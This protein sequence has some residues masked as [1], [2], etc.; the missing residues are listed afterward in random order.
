MDSIIRPLFA[1]CLALATAIPPALNAF[2]HSEDANCSGGFHR[3]DI[4]Y[5]SGARS[6]PCLRAD[7]AEVYDWC[8]GHGGSASTNQHGVVECRGV[9]GDACTGAGFNF[10]KISRGEIVCDITFGS[11][12]SNRTGG[13]AAFDFAASPH[14]CNCKTDGEAV[15]SNGTCGQCAAGQFVINGT[16]ASVGDSCP[17]VSDKIVGSNGVCQCAPEQVIYNGRCSDFNALPQSELCEYFGGDPETAGSRICSGVDDANT[18]CILNGPDFAC[19]GLLRHVWNC[20]ED[21]ERVALDPFLCGKECE[22][23]ENARGGDCEL[24]ALSDDAARLAAAYEAR[25]PLGIS[26]EVQAFYRLAITDLY[27]RAGGES[28]GIL[29]SIEN[30]ADTVNRDSFYSDLSSVYVFYYPTSDDFV[31]ALADAGNDYMVLL[32]TLHESLNDG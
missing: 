10:E 2:A 9:S 19:R 14:H 25:I 28:G 16:C 4:P 21:F 1:L 15:T 29:N 8:H 27:A 6:D 26:E 18:F 11:A 20:N 17:W 22:S 12:C 13:D 32:R 30:H 23:W 24:P 3:P 31:A 5:D 7:Q